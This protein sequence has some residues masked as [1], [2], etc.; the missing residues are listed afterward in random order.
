MNRLIFII[1]LIF[2]FLN[3]N[4]IAGEYASGLRN[5][6]TLEK[7]LNE[8]LEFGEDADV[9]VKLLM[10]LLK[11]DDKSSPL[12]FKVIMTVGSDI[13]I[14]SA[15]KI[16]VKSKNKDLLLL[17]LKTIENLGD[18]NEQADIIIALMNSKDKKIKEQAIIMTGKLKIKKSV[19]KLIVILLDSYVTQDIFLNKLAAK[20]L[21][22]IGDTKAIPALIKGLFVIK[23]FKGTNNNGSVFTYAKNA[24]IKFGNASLKELID[25]LNENSDDFNS[26]VKEQRLKKTDIK[27]NLIVVI[28]ELGGKSVYPILKE[29]MNYEDLGVRVLAISGM[30][31][32]GIYKSVS[33]LIKKYNKLK[34][35]VFKLKNDVKI[36]QIVEELI[37][38]NE[39]LAKIGGKKADKH[40]SKEILAKP[41]KVNAVK[42][43]DL[44]DDTIAS[45]LNF[46][47]YKYYY[48]Y[49][50]AYKQAKEQNRKKANLKYLK[51]MEVSR[52]CKNKVKCYIKYLDLKEGL[53]GDKKE[54]AIMQK[55]KA[56]YMMAIFRKGKSR[57]L[58]IDSIFEKVLLDYSPSIRNA[59]IFTFLRIGNKSD[60]KGMETVIK[61]ALKDKRLKR[62]IS[63]YENTLAKLKNK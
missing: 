11:K 4:I 36:R 3:V 37:K 30:G 39:A 19:D 52:R 60:I 56:I 50:K 28:S 10:S 29:Y 9:D 48:V 62:E 54:L 12:V 38:I 1:M 14:A 32:L 31:N 42:Y 22:E 46:A 13:E 35:Q 23:K 43:N 59:G 16:A 51:T 45:F 26:F 33:V 58:V 15:V 5:S 20:S 40:I 17:S 2:L 27:F 44:K 57:K 63:L 21:G 6:E 18:K 34:K 41:L 8:I 49:K 47:S 55:E 25:T 24:L 61:K 7:T 53:Q